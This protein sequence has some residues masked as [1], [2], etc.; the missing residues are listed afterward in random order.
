MTFP[1]LETELELIADKGSLICLD[2]VGRGAIA[3][4]VV[5]AATVFTQHSAREIPK[6]LKDSKLIAEPKREAIAE[7]AADWLENAVG[8]VSASEI[9]QL[10]I[11]EA[12]KRAALMAIDKLSVTDVPILLDGKHNWLGMEDLVTTKIKA[13]QQCAA[14]SAASIIAKHYRD[15]IMRELDS[16][17]PNYQWSGNKGYASEAHMDAIREFGSTKIHRKTWLTR[18]INSEQMLF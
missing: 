2:E 9:D 16:L 15:E 12:L 17:H 4:P 3:G 8:E 14:V 13:D 5:V 6:G 1:N 10:G 7:L 18:I 11:S